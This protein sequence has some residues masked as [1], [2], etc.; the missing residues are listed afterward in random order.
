MGKLLD[1]WRAKRP[2]KE[3]PPPSFAEYQARVLSLICK[4]LFVLRLYLAMVFSLSRNV[5]ALGLL[6]LSAWCKASYVES[7]PLNAQGLLNESMS[8][9]DNFY[10]PEAGYLYDVSGA[11][12]LRHETRS[13]AWYAV[14]LLARNEG[15]DVKEALKILTNVVDG[16]FKNPEQQWY[17]KISHGSI[18][19]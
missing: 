5:L 1:K 6:P 4:L 10:D 11:A 17:V 9:M 15:E 7:M 12:A 19:E 16:Q 14:G 13:S 8:W 18:K 2:S 3:G